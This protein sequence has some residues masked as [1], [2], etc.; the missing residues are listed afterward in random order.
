[1]SIVRRFRASLP[2]LKKEKKY[3]RLGVSHRRR[4]HVRDEGKRE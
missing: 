3:Y 2:K 4:R 1:M